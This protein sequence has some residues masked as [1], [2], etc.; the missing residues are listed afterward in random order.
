MSRIVRTRKMRAQNT[1]GP[2]LFLFPYAV[3]FTRESSKQPQRVYSI[4][5]YRLVIHPSIHPGCADDA[6]YIGYIARCNP[7]CTPLRLC[8]RKKES[9][10]QR[11]TGG[12]FFSL[13]CVYVRV[14]SRWRKSLSKCV[15]ATIPLF[16]FLWRL[17]LLLDVSV[18]FLSF[19]NQLSDALTRGGKQVNTHSTQ[20]YKE[21]RKERE[22]I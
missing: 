2:F 8:K 15:T 6:L 20:V 1:L 16:S 3:V 18:F 7:S 11:R 9:K 12:R 4:V 19:A 14:L 22:S 13:P 10:N 17:L 5:G 21:G